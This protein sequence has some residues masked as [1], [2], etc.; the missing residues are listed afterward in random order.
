MAIPNII[1]IP[2]AI[3]STLAAT[4]AITDIVGS[5]RTKDCIFTGNIVPSGAPRPYIHI[6]TPVGIDDFSA[7][8]LRGWEATFEILMVSEDTESA[9]ELYNLADAVQEVLH[10]GSLSLSTD[11]HIQTLCVGSTPAITSDDL[12]GLV[13]TYNI[14]I[15][16]DND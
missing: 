13:L 3:H 5:Y 14:I 15:M 11:N 12:V 16:N 7:K 4:S 9:V 1:Q 2:A 6:R 8:D 10:R